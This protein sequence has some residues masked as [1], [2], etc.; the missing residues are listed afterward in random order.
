MVSLAL[1]LLFLINIISLAFSDQSNMSIKVNHTIIGIKKQK[2]NIK[3]ICGIL[4][5]L[6]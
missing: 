6:H 4:Q 1:W 2:E 5:N 3:T